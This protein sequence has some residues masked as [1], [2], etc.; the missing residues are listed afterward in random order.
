MRSEL[1]AIVL[2]KKDE[3]VQTVRNAVPATPPR[4]NKTYLGTVTMAADRR[5]TV[6]VEHYAHLRLVGKYTLTYGPADLHWN[7]IATAVPGI[8]PGETRPIFRD[9]NGTLGDKP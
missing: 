5:F 4:S 6:I 1:A 3:L 9:A 8:K 7:D 2:S